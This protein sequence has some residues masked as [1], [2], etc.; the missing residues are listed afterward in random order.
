MHAI[1]PTNNSKRDGAPQVAGAVP[2]GRAD[3]MKTL[4]VGHHFLIRE[5]LRGV[6]KELKN[7]A[8]ML[9]ARDGQEAMR[10]LSERTDIGLII[11]DL[12]LPDGSGLSALGGMRERHPAIPVVIVSGAHDYHTILRALNLGAR[13]F[14]LKSDERQIMVR[15]LELVFA[16]GIY[17]PR[18][19]LALE[20]SSGTRPASPRGSAKAH[21]CSLAELDLTRR[22]L[23]VLSAMMQGKCNK[24][25]CR[26]LNLA[27]STV[28]NHVTAILRK[29]G[30]RSRVEAVLAVGALGWE[31]PSADQESPRRNA[32]SAKIVRLPNRLLGRA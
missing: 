8:A 22:Q 3:T 2:F 15:A 5:A 32:G 17:I 1:T 25:I 4:L 7:D 21:P 27:E 6:L 26:E 30:V 29:L 19:I 9:D 31:Q 23:D 16:G 20:D 18:E 28:K 24:A 12:D 11:L 13:G 14:I 10:L